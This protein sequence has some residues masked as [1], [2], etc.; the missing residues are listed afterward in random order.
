MCLYIFRPLTTLPDNGPMSETLVID[1]NKDDEVL[2]RS[3]L[4]EFFRRHTDLG[5]FCEREE[6]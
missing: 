3:L 5:P 2:C 1:I 4:G 6:R